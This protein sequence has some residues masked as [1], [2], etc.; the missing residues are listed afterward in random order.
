[1]I[2]D[3]RRRQM[4]RARDRHDRFDRWFTVILFIVV[5]VIIG[6]WIAIGLVAWHFLG[7]VW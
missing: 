4:E 1:M 3:Q 6:F 2:P 7:K 5:C